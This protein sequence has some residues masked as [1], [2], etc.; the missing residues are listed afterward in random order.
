VIVRNAIVVLTQPKDPTVDVV[1]DRLVELGQPVVR[2]DTG[3]FPH[4][5]QLTSRWQDG[6]LATVLHAGGDDIDVSSLRSIWYRRPGEFGFVPSMTPNTRAFA[7]AE[8]RQAFSG[9]LLTSPATW[10]NRPDAESVASLKMLQLEIAARRGLTIPETLVTNDPDQARAFLGSEG[11]GEETIYKRLA[12][13]L[14]WT[15]D[16][17]LTA[18]ETEKVDPAARERLDAVAVTPCLFQRYVPKQYEIRATVVSGQVIAARVDSQESS[19]AAVDWRADP[20]LA[21]HPYT[22]PPDVEQAVIDVVDD[23]GL[24]FGAVDLIRRPD[25]GYTFLEVN[26]S[27]QWAWFDDEITFRIRDA[28]VQLLTTPE[29]DPRCMRSVVMR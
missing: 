24:L 28:I 5:T 12:A 27:G 22:L 15:E 29:A 4:E 19:S 13:M 25:G 1:Q 9:A 8:A 6:R 17:R 16:Q 11:P 7:T 3:T 10:M 18:F 21:W 20:D 2:L 14:L 23:L 26:P